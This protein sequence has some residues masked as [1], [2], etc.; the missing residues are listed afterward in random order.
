MPTAL[1]IGPY[2]FFFYANDGIEAEHIH[3]RR[4][5]NVAKFWLDPIRL[6]K[7][8]GFGKAELRNIQ[9]SVREH[10]TEL[11]KAWHEYFET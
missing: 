1:R 5:E 4:D 7:S 9:E 8:A 11:L 10:Q 6:E 3:V 2:R